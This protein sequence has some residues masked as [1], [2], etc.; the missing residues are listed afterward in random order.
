MIQKSPH[1]EGKNIIFSFNAKLCFKTS[2]HVL[3]GVD[4]II[5]LLPERLY[6]FRTMKKIAAITIDYSIYYL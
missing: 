5:F 3:V 6:F 2:K 4:E 1:E